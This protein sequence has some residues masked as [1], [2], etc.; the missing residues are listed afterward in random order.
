MN[1]KKIELAKDPILVKKGGKRTDQQWDILEGLGN[2]I[3]LFDDDDEQ[4]SRI[5]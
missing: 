4:V 1:Q 2:M 3:M 5:A